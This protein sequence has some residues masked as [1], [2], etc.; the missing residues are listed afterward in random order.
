MWKVAYATPEELKIEGNDGAAGKEV[1][2]LSIK[3]DSPEK[4][5]HR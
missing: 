4:V 2:A 3:S 1:D 5:E